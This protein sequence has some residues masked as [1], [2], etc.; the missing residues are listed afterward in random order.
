MLN[1][2]KYQI[3]LTFCKGLGP[4]FSKQLIKS[5][6]TAENVWNK[7]LSTIHPQPSIPLK[8]LKDIGS[9]NLL[10]QAEKEL[11]FCLQNQI[12]V[13]SYFQD[14]YPALLK[15]CVDAPL[16]LYYKGNL[17]KHPKSIAIVGS[18]KM[19][20]YGGMFIQTL[21]ED[22]RNYELNIISGLAYGC[23]IQAHRMA[24]EVGLPNWAILAHH[25]GKIYPSQHKKEAEAILDTGGWI[26]EYNSQQ[27]IVPENFLQRNRIIAG[28]ADATIVVESAFSGGALVTAKFANDYNRDVFALPGRL[29]DEMSKGN[30]HLIK[31]HQAYLI[32]RA[33]DLLYQL[34]LN[35]SKITKQAQASLFAELTV[36][37]TKILDLLKAHQKLHLDQLANLSGQYTYQLLPILLDLELKMVVKP[38]PGKFFELY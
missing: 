11:D 4:I 25:L 9:P 22:L 33:E 3:A 32:E 24:L 35:S 38:L 10:E 15:E 21:L 27:A 6:S 18:R 20:A 1:D 7:K 26:S 37:E 19:T 8:A 5:H 30:N 12:K 29:N 16:V 2:L 17:L 13:V 31:S 23:D 28:L 14:E 34:D 36:N